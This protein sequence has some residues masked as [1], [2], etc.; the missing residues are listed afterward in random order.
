MYY[1]YSTASTNQMNTPLQPIKPGSGSRPGPGVRLHLH[2]AMSVL[3]F[4]LLPKTM[5]ALKPHKHTPTSWTSQGRSHSCLHGLVL[6]DSLPL[7]SVCLSLPNTH[8]SLPPPSPSTLHHTHTH[9]LNSM[10][11]HYEKS[12]AL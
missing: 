2:P 12:H 1:Y 11:R 5:S 8:L 10:C 7:K 9:K 3:L 6:Q 4:L